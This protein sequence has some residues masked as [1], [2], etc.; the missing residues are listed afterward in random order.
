MRKKSSTSPC[1][2]VMEGTSEVVKLTPQDQARVSECIVDVSVA[3]LIEKSE[4]TQLVHQ[5]Q[6]RKLVVEEIVGVAGPLVMEETLEVAKCTPR[7]RVQ[8]RTLDVTEEVPSPRIWESLGEANQREHDQEPNMND[9]GRHSHVDGGN[10]HDVVLVSELTR[11]AICRIPA[12]SKQ[13]KKRRR[14]RKEEKGQKVERGAECEDRE[15][16]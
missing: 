12:A 15:N 1:Q 10:V 4:V 3:Q 2:Q 9:L 5:L 16:E 14:R 13:G 7:K 8:G 6:T 11:T